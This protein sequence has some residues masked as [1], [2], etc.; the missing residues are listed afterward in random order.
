MCTADTDETRDAARAAGWK[1]AARLVASATRN[2]GHERE[3]TILS[4][5]CPFVRTRARAEP[6]RR[7]RRAHVCGER[8]SP[9]QPTKNIVTRLCAHA[10]DSRCPT[11]DLE[12]Y[13]PVYKYSLRYRWRP[14]V[15]VLVVFL[16]ASRGTHGR[17][18]MSG[19]APNR[20]RYR[21]LCRYA[22]TSSM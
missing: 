8:R 4:L 18:V 12:G 15:D 21:W 2:I 19:I 16:A 6:P 11:P 10:P 17:T 7:S 9:Q 20:E 14:P 1:A 13:A 22:I 5:F 3:N